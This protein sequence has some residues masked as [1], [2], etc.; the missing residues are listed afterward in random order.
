MVKRKVE[1]TLVRALR[2]CRGHMAHSGSRGKALHFLDHGTRRGEGQC[3]APAALYPP[4]KTRYPFYRRLGGPQGRSG[5]EEYLVTTGIR[6]RTA[7]PVVSHYTDW[8]TRLTLVVF[9]RLNNTYATWDFSVKLITTLLA[10][11]FSSHDCQY[12][13]VLTVATKNYV[14]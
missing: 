3:H 6:Y 9:K 14:W 13:V 7:H 4:G 5:R 10:V 11:Y 1:C 2:L 12:F 8:A